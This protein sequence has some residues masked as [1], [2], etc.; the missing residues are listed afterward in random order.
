MRTSARQRPEDHPGA[1]GLRL[2]AI[3]GEAEFGGTRSR[4]DV[5]TERR[6]RQWGLA[7]TRP[8]REPSRRLRRRRRTP[9][10]LSPPLEG[11]G[12]PRHPRH[13]DDGLLRRPAPSRRSSIGAFLG[14]KVGAGLIAGKGLRLKRIHDN[15]KLIRP[16]MPEAA[17]DGV[18]LRFHEVFGRL[19]AEMSHMRRLAGHMRIEGEDLLASSPQR[20]LISRRPAHGQLGGGRGQ[21]GRAR[22]AARQHRHPA[23]PARPPPHRHAAAHRGRR[24]PDRALAAGPAQIARHLEERRAAG[25][26]LRRDRSAEPPARP[27][28]RP[29]AR[30][31]RQHRDGRPPRPQDQRPSGGLPRPAREGLDLVWKLGPEITLPDVPIGPDQITADLLAVNAA[32]EPVV[33]DAVDQWY[34][35]DSI[36]R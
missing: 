16:D 22:H 5:R 27:L 28:L 8:A 10:R 2:L 13:R 15:L 17:Y 9:G 11:R 34:W 33:R 29:Q 23:A 18:V 20:P 1:P 19:M 30:S 32:I 4:R 25:R 7:G 14:R 31:A 35:L 3:R 21:G 26:V 36:I 12:S 24:D 6:P